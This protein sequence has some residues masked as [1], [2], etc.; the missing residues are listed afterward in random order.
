MEQSGEKRPIEHILVSHRLLCA[1]Q[2]LR[3]RER[4]ADLV[5]D[6]VLHGI[7]GGLVRHAAG[8]ADEV[9]H[10]LVGHADDGVAFDVVVGPV[11]GGTIWTP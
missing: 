2:Q 3:G 6:D 11:S 9:D 8:A 5:D 10:D 4:Y 7:L 1:P